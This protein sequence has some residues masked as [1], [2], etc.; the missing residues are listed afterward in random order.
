MDLFS[1]YVKWNLSDGVVCYFVMNIGKKR[2]YFVYGQY[3]NLYIFNSVEVIS[4]FPKV[5]L[6]PT[7]CWKFQFYWR[8]YIENESDFDRRLYFKI[9]KFTRWMKLILTKTVLL[10]SVVV[11]LF[12]I[13]VQYSRWFLRFFVLI[14]FKS[15]KTK[16]EPLKSIVASFYMVIILWGWKKWYLLSFVPRLRIC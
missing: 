4:C 11:V 16:I 6:W 2:N 3:F 13:R 12:F 1:G 15:H 5:D 14:N 9:K 10:L 8:C 7:N